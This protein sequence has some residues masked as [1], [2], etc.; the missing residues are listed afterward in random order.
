MKD[1]VETSTARRP[2]LLFLARTFPP[3]ASIG[4]VRTWNIAKC[5]ARLGWEVTVVTPDARLIRNPDNLE[6]SF[7]DIAKEGIRQIRTGHQ[8]RFLDPGILV[9]WDRGAG[10]FFGGICRRI[11]GLLGISR[12]IGW[13]KAAE[14]ACSGL[15]A[16][17]VDLILASG[18][19]FAPFVLAERL[20]KRLDRP[21]ILDYRDPWW[22]EV[23]GMIR[24]LQP[25]IDRLESRLLAGA[26]AVIIVSSSWADD[27]DRR[28]KIRSKLHVITN[29]YDPEDLTDVKPQEFGHFAIVYTGI[30]Y[31]PT[32]VI[33]P[34]LEALKRLRSRKGIEVEWYFHYYGSQGAH[35]SEVAEKLGITECVKLHGMVP[36]S[37]AQSAIKGAD[38]SVVI[39]SVFAETSTEIDG[40]IP[41]KLFETVGL[42]T[43][44]L[45]IAPPGSD[46][47]LIAEPTGLSHR[48]TGDD[49][50]GIVSFLEQR[51]SGARPRQMRVESLT[52]SSLANKL[53]GVLRKELARSQRSIAS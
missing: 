19:P 23:M 1:G 45:L 40:W 44:V 4:S 14:Q 37:Q 32:R 25:F 43:P 2:R 16:D 12:G 47:A 33:T 10:W 34:V 17:D 48:I 11:A 41:A 51:L 8:L 39:A 31:P 15:G 7:A 42:G 53:D 24:G 3:V 5:L 36:R 38:I 27:L 49:I 9:C 18:P 13:I 20:S 50:D 35:V 46:A 30:F 28:F 52:W 6:Q 21:Y 29:G 26:R 22:T